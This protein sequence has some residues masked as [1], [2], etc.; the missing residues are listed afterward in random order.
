MQNQGPLHSDGAEHAPVPEGSTFSIGEVSALLAVPAPTIRSWERRHTLFPSVRDEHGHR[1]YTE[2]DVAVLRRMRDQRAGGVRV[3][4]AVATAT[5]APPSVLCQQVL[6][7]IHRLDDHGIRAA[8]DSSLAA[9]GLPVTLEEVLL[10]AMREVGAQWTRGESD[11]AHEHLATAAVL[12]W[13][14]RRAGEA[15]PPLR[16]RPIVLSCGPLD[17]H[18][19]ALEAFVVLLRHHRFDCLNLGA[20]TPADAL[21]VAVQ[22]SGAAAVVLV[23]QLASNRAAAVAALRAV[24]DTQAA[25]FYA[26]GAFRSS[27][28]RQAVPGSYLGGSLFQAVQHI[29]AHL[30]AAEANRGADRSG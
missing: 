22:Q 17:Q 26:G 20:Q 18:T 9:H 1:R 24:G 10:P 11:I 7:A 21:R 25:L 29:A 30:R 4:E 3:S 19:I 6:A 28:S 13:L 8:L 15:P 27:R 5:T 23:S 14:A 2:A 16:E 12:A